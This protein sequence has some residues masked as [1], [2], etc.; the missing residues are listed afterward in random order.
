VGGLL[1]GLVISAVMVGVLALPLWFIAPDSIRYPALYSWKYSV[2]RSHVYVDK[3]AADCDWSYAPIGDK[4][5]HYDNL[6][7]PLMN[8]QGKVTDVYVMWQ[9]VE[10]SRFWKL[11]DEIGLCVICLI[12]G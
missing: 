6:V 2:P 4:D 10:V 9:K 11:M 3:K 8:A 5:C 12:S 1:L 7:E